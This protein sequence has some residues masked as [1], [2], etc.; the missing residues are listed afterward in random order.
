MGLAYPGRRRFNRV[1]EDRAEDACKIRTSFVRVVGTCKI[2]ASS[3]RV[4]DACRIRKGARSVMKAMRQAE[5]RVDVARISPK[6]EGG[7][8][9]EA[10]AVGGGRGVA[11]VTT[12][13]R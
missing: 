1:W 6:A 3:V 10:P 9:G 2:R 13:L 4:V 5:G 8:L 11:A 7:L 12:S